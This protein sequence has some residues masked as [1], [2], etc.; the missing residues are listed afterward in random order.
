MTSRSTNRRATTKN[1]VRRV[2]GRIVNLGRPRLLVAIGYKVRDST[3]L[4]IFLSQYLNGQT[5]ECPTGSNELP[6]GFAMGNEQVPLPPAQPQ[7][8]AGLQ[9][10]PLLFQ[11]PTMGNTEFS[12]LRYLIRLP[13]AFFSNH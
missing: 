6:F 3:L 8:N 10:S 11:S 4:G 7:W 12:V 2:E 13:N 9:Q 5:G 1:L